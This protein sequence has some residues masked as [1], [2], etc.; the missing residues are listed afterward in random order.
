MSATSGIDEYLADGFE[1]ALDDAL[2]QHGRTL[3][4][5]AHNLLPHSLQDDHRPQLTQFEEWASEFADYRATFEVTG[6]EDAT[7][8]NTRWHAG[9][10]YLLEMMEV[11]MSESDADGRTYTKLQV[12]VFDTARDAD[13]LEALRDRPD[14]DDSDDELAYHALQ[15]ANLSLIP[16]ATTAI[17]DLYYYHEAHEEGDE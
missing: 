11:H 8:S 9:H 1:T 12:R 3:A 6:P 5:V 10:G 14:R 4:L 17:L 2:D 7:L 13:P 15:E 16:D